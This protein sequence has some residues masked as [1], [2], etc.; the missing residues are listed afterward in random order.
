M[1]S[2]FHIRKHFQDKIKLKHY[3]CH[4]L[5]SPS[6][7]III[8]IIKLNT[9]KAESC[10]FPWMGLD[11]RRKC[12][13]MIYL[14]ISKHQLRSTLSCVQ[15]LPAHISEPISLVYLHLIHHRLCVFKSACVL[16]PSHTHLTKSLRSSSWTKSCL[17]RAGSLETRAFAR[18]MMLYREI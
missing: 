7:I 13:C 8:I 15:S 4:Q 2:A 11:S 14:R 10:I 9:I 3:L 12:H 17:S 1:M 16:Y 18:L 5:D 6:L